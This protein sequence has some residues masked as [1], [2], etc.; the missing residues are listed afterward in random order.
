MS[1][2]HKKLK[3]TFALNDNGKHTKI[4]FLLARVIWISKL[5]IYRKNKK[6]G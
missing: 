2:H 3:Y 5:L 6:F 1:N 4:E